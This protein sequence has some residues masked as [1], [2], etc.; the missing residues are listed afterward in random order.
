MQWDDIKHICDTWERISTQ[1]LIIILV[2]LHSSSFLSMMCLYLQSLKFL[3]FYFTVYCIANLKAS[4]LDYNWTKATSHLKGFSYTIIE[5]RVQFIT[6]LCL[7]LGHKTVWGWW[8]WRPFYVK[9]VTPLHYW[10]FCIA[11][12]H[13]TPEQI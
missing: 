13:S 9:P 5:Y 1:F 7:Y 6:S 2:I 10:I 11:F 3:V 4:W 12:L 8:D